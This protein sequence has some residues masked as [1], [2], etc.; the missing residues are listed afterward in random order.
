MYS[1]HLPGWFDCFRSATQVY[2]P[3][4]LRI[5]LLFN[6]NFSVF[7]S[8][9]CIETIHLAVHFIHRGPL[10]LQPCCCY[11]LRSCSAT[12]GLSVSLRATWNAARWSVCRSRH[13]PTFSQLG[14]ELATHNSKV[15]LSV[16][17]V[18]AHSP[19]SHPP[20]HT[21]STFESRERAELCWYLIYSTH[22]DLN[23]QLFHFASNNLETKTHN[24]CAG[25]LNW[26]TEKQCWFKEICWCLLLAL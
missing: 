11:P 25:D 24:R 21:P 14:F 13:P 8:F 10:H 15:G 1:K 23:V 12:N 16:H 7:F 3:Q 18:P 26:F 2:L 17:E 19:T 22:S 6:Y 9:L 20:T 4:I 5:C